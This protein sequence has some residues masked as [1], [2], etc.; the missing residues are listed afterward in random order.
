MGI[1]FFDDFIIIIIFKI[2]SIKIWKQEV[3]MGHQTCFQI[4]FFHILITKKILI[5][6]VKPNI[7]L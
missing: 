7:P 2:F 1:N 6:K 4:F 5:I 3:K